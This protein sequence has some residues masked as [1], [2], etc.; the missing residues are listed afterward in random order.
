MTTMET[1]LTI[2]TLL[3]NIALFVTC[4]AMLNRMGP[5]T[6]HGVRFSI[7]LIAVGAAWN[8]LATKYGWFSFMLPA[9][10]ALFFVCSKRTS[11]FNYSHTERRCQ[12]I[13][14]DGERH[15]H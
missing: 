14:K 6:D 12:K 11:S 13:T 7:I 3:A 10:A 9:G 2:F 4:S 8:I 15:V 1:L 5:K